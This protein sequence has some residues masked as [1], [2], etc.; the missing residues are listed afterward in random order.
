M[1]NAMSEV[2]CS[3]VYLGDIIGPISIICV[4]VI[5]TVCATP[6]VRIGGL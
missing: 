6:L 4:C 1:A 5:M 3:R 2:V